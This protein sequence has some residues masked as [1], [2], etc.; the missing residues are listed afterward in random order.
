MSE[1][2]K[3]VVHQA[4]YLSILTEWKAECKLKRCKYNAHCRENK[5]LR[6]EQDGLKSNTRIL[7]KI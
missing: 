3:V 7:G 2:L 4:Y 6:N 5:G 1:K